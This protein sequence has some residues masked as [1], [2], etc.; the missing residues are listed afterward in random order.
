LYSAK[1]LYV[2]LALFLARLVP[3]PPRLELVLEPGKQYI[4]FSLFYDLTTAHNGRRCPPFA[5]DLS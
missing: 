2:G 4:I 1:M 5:P 3:L